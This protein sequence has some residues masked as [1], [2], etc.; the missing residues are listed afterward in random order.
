MNSMK[1][2]PSSIYENINEILAL[3]NPIMLPKPIALDEYTRFIPR[4]MKNLSNKENLIK[5]L[6]DILSNEL[7][8]EYNP[9]NKTHSSDLEEVSQKFMALNK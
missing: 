3:W 7:G 5:C 6:E 4:I 8:L 2:K 9:N 1:R